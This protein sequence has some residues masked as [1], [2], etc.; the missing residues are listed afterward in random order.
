[1]SA[2]G[3]AG[4]LPGRGDSASAVSHGT[5]ELDLWSTTAGGAG[6]LPGRG[7]S[8]I[9]VSHGDWDLDVWRTEAVSAGEADVLPE[10]ADA[11]L[12]SIGEIANVWKCKVTVF[13]SAIVLI[14]EQF[15]ENVRLA[16][17]D[18]GAEKAKAR[19]ITDRRSLIS[20]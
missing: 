18:S 16:A 11:K 5:G 2:A 8:A 1:M 20:Y 4:V 3:G 9:A 13:K 10:K 15:G 19:M 14:R 7:D 12:L 6:V 17:C